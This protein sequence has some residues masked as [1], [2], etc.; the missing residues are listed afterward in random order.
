MKF[1]IL[2]ILFPL[3]SYA[4]KYNT[5]CT[6]TQNVP[7]VTAYNYMT[8]K[9]G[10]PVKEIDESKTKVRFIDRQTITP[11]KGKMIVETMMKGPHVVSDQ[12][13]RE[14]LTDIYIKM[15]VYVLTIKVDFESFSG[16]KNSFIVSSYINDDEC[17]V[18]DGGLI[19]LNR[20]F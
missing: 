9:L 4:D 2:L 7:A 8:D 10:I 14:I 17:S 18:G 19:M 13:A 20:G 15:R 5:S 6:G 16:K 3:V 1:L 12:M 11:L